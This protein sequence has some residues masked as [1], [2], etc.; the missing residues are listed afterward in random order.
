MQ[1]TPRR[2]AEREVIHRRF[3]YQ[4]ETYPT[5]DRISVIHSPSDEASRE[6]NPWI[7][8]PVRHQPCE[9]DNI[10]YN[11]DP[12]TRRAHLPSSTLTGSAARNVRT[13]SSRISHGP[14]YL[15]ARGL[16]FAP[17]NIDVMCACALCYNQSTLSLPFK[18][19]HQGKLYLLQQ[20]RA[21]Q[22]RR[23]EQLYSS[24]L[25]P[26]DELPFHPLQ[27]ARYSKS[28]SRRQQGT[29]RDYKPAAPHPGLHGLFKGF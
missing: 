19:Q 12:Q 5:A 8:A 2:K 28:V 10:A 15:E 13:S 26:G 16:G 29:Y 22:Q 3:P 17:P 25:S 14:T 9:S 24:S 21:E 11:F 1:V 4:L 27:Q 20:S 7:V 18:N 23:R 6:V